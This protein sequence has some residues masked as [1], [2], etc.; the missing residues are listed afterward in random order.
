MECTQNIPCNPCQDACPHHC[1]RVGD[2]ITALPQVD[3]T[4]KCVGCG[5][6]VA[7]CSGQAV[8]LLEENYAPGFAAVTIPYEF[9]PLPEKGE[10]G[11]GLGRRGEPLCEAEV[12]Q[13]K[14][15][16]AFDK[17][18]LVTLKIPGDMAMRVRFY[19]KEV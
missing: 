19:R 4:K 6:C 3:D 8:F 16:G 11:T 12:V 9:L 7:S 13:V 2:D 15:S 14:T 1:I 5:L 18:N 10:K 17:T